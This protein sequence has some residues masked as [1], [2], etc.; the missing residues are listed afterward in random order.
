[1][2]D[3][4]VTG[5]CHDSF[6]SL[7][8]RRLSLIAHSK[9]TILGF[10]ITAGQLAGVV[11]QRLASSFVAPVG[12]G[13]VNELRALVELGYNGLCVSLRMRMRI[14]TWS[15]GYNTLQELHLP[16]PVTSSH[17]QHFPIHHTLPQLSIHLH[18]ARYPSEPARWANVPSMDLILTCHDFTNHVF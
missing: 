14:V 15:D 5:K 9:Q 8:R 12:G 17:I 16:A 6:A 1:M 10:S 13:V 3:C 18:H 11:T 2:S 7:R 4:R